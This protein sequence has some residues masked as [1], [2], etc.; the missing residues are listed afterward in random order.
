MAVGLLSL[1]LCSEALS[2]V[3]IGVTVQ[4]GEQGDGRRAAAVLEDYAATTGIPRA[5]LLLRELATEDVVA[6]EAVWSVLRPAYASGSLAGAA[7]ELQRGV[8][9]PTVRSGP[10]SL[11][12][13][14]EMARLRATFAQ[15]AAANTTSLIAVHMIRRRWAPPDASVPASTQSLASFATP[16][17]RS[18]ALRDEVEPFPPVPPESLGPRD[19]ARVMAVAS[20]LIDVAPDGWTPSLLLS[21]VPFPDSLAT[22]ETFVASESVTLR[23]AA[24]TFGVRAAMFARELAPDRS[25][26]FEAQ[27]DARL[28]R[29]SGRYLAVLPGFSALALCPVAT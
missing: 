14:G 20:K 10:A 18:P 5:P 11:G 28:Q 17:R 27:V 15:F 16:D 13:G 26:R 12:D 4:G 22:I 2:D 25:A 23:A 29:W 8:A 19:L 1:L 24:R 21:L 6:L 7:Q 3:R 9:L